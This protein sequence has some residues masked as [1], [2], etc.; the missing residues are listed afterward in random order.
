MPSEL[1]SETA[2][3]N[4]AKSRGPWRIRRFVSAETV[5][6]IAT[7][8]NVP[9]HPAARSHPQPKRQRGGDSHPSPKRQRGEIPTHNPKRQR[10]DFR[11]K[12]NIAKRT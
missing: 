2:R 11:R 3:I 10:G 4:G 7:T 12:Q 9:P 8:P 6:K 1:K 5:L